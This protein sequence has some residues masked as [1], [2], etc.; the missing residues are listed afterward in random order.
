MNILVTGGAGYI[1]SHT[2]LELIN[3][4]HRPVIVD[5][6]SN[7]SK[8]VIDRLN[9][10][11]SSEI[12]YYEQDF[13]DQAAVKQI[14]ETEKIEGVIHFAAFKAVAESVADPLRYYQN[15]TAGFANL[16]RT[17]LDANVQTIIFSS[18]AAVYGNPP[19]DLVTEDTPCRPESPYGWSKLM[20][21]IILRDTCAATPT[22]H[23]T[24]L[25][26]FNVVGSHD[27]GRIGESPKT[28]PQ[29]LLP[30]IVQAVNGTIPPLTVMGTDYPTPD[31]TCLRDYI[32]VVDLAKAHIAALEH[33]AS[34][35]N[36]A[37][38]VY[39]IG[40][41]KPTSVLEL[42][43]TFETVND[44]AVPHTLGERRP[45]DPVACYASAE[46][47]EKELG[48]KAEKTIEDACR[49]AWRWQTQNP[50]GY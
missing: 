45:G 4:G 49:D 28:K 9:E 38:E 6:F 18:T 14:I 21:E 7:S 44:V 29:N 11:T 20:D 22:L 34:Q 33:A 5:N 36:G 1:G 8:G 27:S 19:E 3:A 37:F 30:I 10:I 13:Q 15:N 39:N 16:V 31:G 47:A 12:K 42:I 23:G 32:H 46:K 24:A 40:T 48:W 43:K 35:S 2:V 50:D 41:G 26:Y 25:R 17:V